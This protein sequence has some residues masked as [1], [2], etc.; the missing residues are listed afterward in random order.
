MGGYWFYLT[1]YSVF[2]HQKDVDDL[3]DKSTYCHQ[4]STGAI[5]RRK[6]QKGSDSFE[7]T[8]TIGILVLVAV[9]GFLGKCD[10]TD[11]TYI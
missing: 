11:L 9:S 7:L 6:T 10:D 3:A 8:I 5:I 1:G 4:K 2:V